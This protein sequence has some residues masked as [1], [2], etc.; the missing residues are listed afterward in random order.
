[1]KKD[2]QHRYLGFKVFIAAG[3]LLGIGLLTQTITTYYYVSRNMVRQEALRDAGR[4]VTSI[5][6]AVRAAGPVDRERVDAIIDETMKEWQGQVAW[7]R[8]V[9]PSGKVMLT[10]GYPDGKVLKR[11]PDVERTFEL[12][13]I[14]EGEVMVS[15][16]PIRLPGFGRAPLTAELAIDMDSISGSFASLQRNLI[17]GVS[18]AVALLIALIIIG[19]R[20]P[21]YL[22]GQKLDHQVAVAR[23]VQA[24][25]LP[26]SAVMHNLDFA[27]ESRPA[28]DVAGDICDV[29]ETDGGKTA[30]VLGDVCGKGMPAA[31]LMGLMHGAVHSST[32]TAAKRDHEDASERLNDLLRRKTSADRFASMFWGY[33]DPADSTL[34]YVNAGHMPQLLL[35]GE[36]VERLEDGGPVL[37]IMDW[38][39]YRQG[40]AHIEEGDLLVM[41]SDGIVEAMDAHKEEFGDERLLAVIQGNRDRSTSEI[42]D[43][44]PERV[45]THVGNRES[46]QD[47]QTLLVIRFQNV[48]HCQDHEP[49][50]MRVGRH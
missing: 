36:R 5:E 42:R 44:I 29:F 40:E 28:N 15:L 9:D 37:G 19:V 24:A 7:L 27:V 22:R 41:F 39:G 18:A 33:Y 14:E 13:D 50:P 47:D 48:L 8:V 6:R 2:R 49:D 26:E 34:R 35:R 32:W 20:F 17:L 12:R 23:T 46:V 43:A 25:L 4:K 10:S 31:L 21:N 3:F 30:F 16:N 11:K 1:M 38:G 45:R